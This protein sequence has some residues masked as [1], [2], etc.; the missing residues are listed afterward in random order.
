MLVNHTTNIARNSYFLLILLVILFYQKDESFDDDK[1]S[2][3][4]RTDLMENHR[5]ESFKNRINIGISKQSLMRLQQST[6][7]IRQL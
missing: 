1:I 5:E 4:N 2:S 6:I 7:D 3:M